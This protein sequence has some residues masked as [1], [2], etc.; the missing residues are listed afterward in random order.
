MI[1]D[2]L[3]IH[4]ACAIIESADRILVAQRSATMSHPLKWEFPGGKLHPGET[5]EEC[6][7]R[8][9]H[10][11]MGVVI[12]VGRSLRHVTHNYPA[13]KV[14]LYP[15]ICAITSGEI[16]LHEHAGIVRLPANELRNLDWAEAD[17]PVIEEYL[18]FSNSK[19]K[20]SA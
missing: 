12:S 4:V 1:A 15:F 9:I 19:S 14:T 8:E 17:L 13:F 2:T 20:I 5:P 6:L 18:R 7:R 11:E 3:H 10:E 16:V